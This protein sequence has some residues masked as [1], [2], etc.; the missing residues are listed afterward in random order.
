L[1]ERGIDKGVIKEKD[2]LFIPGY[3]VSNS[4]GKLKYIEQEILA[5]MGISLSDF[6][7]RDFESLSLLGSKRNAF[8]EV[9]DVLIETGT[10]ELFSK[11]K[12]K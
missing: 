11:G 10:D 2:S 4:G 9:K 8:F 3:N 12:A 5:D 1:L 6:R 7:N